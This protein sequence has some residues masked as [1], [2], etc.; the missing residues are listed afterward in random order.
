MLLSALPASRRSDGRQQSIRD[1]IDR[2]VAVDRG[3][4]SVL[5]IVGYNQ[6]QGAQLLAQPSLNSGRLIVGALV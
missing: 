1:A 3:Q 4:D 6:I 2:L 5:S